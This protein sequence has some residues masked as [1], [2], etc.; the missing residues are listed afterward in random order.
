MLSF[1]SY[2]TKPHNFL[3]W[4]TS[5]SLDKALRNHVVYLSQVIL[6]TVHLS[7]AQRKLRK[8]GKE[9]AAKKGKFQV[10]FDLRLSHACRIF[11]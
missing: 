6:D 10:T 2:S 11:S 7:R 5:L 1:L 8:R 3:Q 4:K 9:R